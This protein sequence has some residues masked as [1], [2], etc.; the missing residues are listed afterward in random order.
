ML[1]IEELKKVS[2][3]PYSFIGEKFGKLKVLSIVGRSDNNYNYFAICECDCGTRRKFD[4]NKLRLGRTKSCG[5]GRL[6][7]IKRKHKENFGLASAYSFYNIYKIGAERRGLEFS[8]SLKY[9]SKLVKGNCY[10]CSQEPNRKRKSHSTQ[11]DYILANGIDR[12][13]NNKGYIK[14]NC[15]S[16]C[17]ICNIAK[18]THSKSQFLRAVEK[19]YLYKIKK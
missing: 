14:G 1:L 2:E 4:L 12:V 13:N 9:F 17:T 16:C 5:C 18:G 15:V 3:I 19:I 10:Y 7:G 6:E 11:T 8:I